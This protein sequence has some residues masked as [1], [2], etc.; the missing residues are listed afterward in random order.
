MLWLSHECFLF[1]LFQAVEDAF[2][3]YCSQRKVVGI[4]GHRMVGGFRASLYNAVSEENVADLVAIIEE[5]EKQY[6]S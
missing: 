3:A 4:A 1:F 2:L 6:S 5:F